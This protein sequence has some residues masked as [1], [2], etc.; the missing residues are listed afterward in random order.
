MARSAS[1]GDSVAV[2]CG[3]G[4]EL[5]MGVGVGV[6][7]L[8]RGISRW[9]GWAGGRRGAAGKHQAKHNRDS[10]EAML[11]SHK[12]SPSRMANWQNS[13]TFSMS[14]VGWAVRPM[15]RITRP[16]RTSPRSQLRDGLSLAL[17]VFHKARSAGSVSCGYYAAGI[18]S[19]SI[20]PWIIPLR[21][22]TAL[23]PHAPEQLFT[24]PHSHR[25][26]E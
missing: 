22:P 23:K 10:N 11:V 25:G 16:A 4:V 13:S 1:S 26:S 21:R 14:R 9:W 18:G 20:M 8:S 24:Y 6:F 5:G 17:T 15:S 2:G 3:V 7:F 12:S 19:R